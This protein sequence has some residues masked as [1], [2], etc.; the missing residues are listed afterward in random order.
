MGAAPGDG[1]EHQHGAARGQRHRQLAGREAQAAP[2][3]WCR[4]KQR[5]HLRAGLGLQIQ[6]PPGSGQG[7][8][9]LK[10]S[11]L[12]AQR[13]R[14]PLRR[15]SMGAGVNHV[16]PCKRPCSGQVGGV[17]APAHGCARAMHQTRQGTACGAACMTYSK[18]GVF[19]SLQAVHEA[20]SAP[21]GAVSSQQ[22]KSHSTCCAEQGAFSPAL[23]PSHRPAAG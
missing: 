17:R 19:S 18:P 6:Q 5:R 1:P 9:G 15:G 21:Q 12:A 13:S 2:G 20:Q 16:R 8:V 22:M 7:G 23:A 3:H 4:S 11:Y 10:S 14:Q